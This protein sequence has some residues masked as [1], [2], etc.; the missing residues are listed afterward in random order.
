MLLICALQEGGFITNQASPQP[1]REK[2]YTV[3]RSYDT[4]SGRVVTM[5]TSDDSPNVTMPTA[6]IDTGRQVRIIPLSTVDDVI[7]G[8]PLIT[9]REVKT[10]TSPSEP[11]PGVCDIISDVISEVDTREGG[12]RSLDLQGGKAYRSSPLTPV[13][14]PK[15]PLDKLNLSPAPSPGHLSGRTSPSMARVVC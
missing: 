12:A 3:G 14:P 5:T 8:G 7:T 10:P 4:A 2:G 9:I 13:L 6:S 15:S 11:P 1:I